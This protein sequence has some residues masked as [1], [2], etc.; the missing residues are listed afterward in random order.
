M[1]LSALAPNP[2]DTRRAVLHQLLDESLRLGP[3]YE[4]GMASH[5]PMALAALD[6]LGAHEAQMRSFHAHYARRLAPAPA[7]AVATAGATR[8]R[9]DG[10]ID[11]WRS[12]RGRI[13]AFAA[14]R[15]HF[16]AAL[17]R[18]GRDALLRD[19]LPALMGGCAGG[20][21]HG[22]IR[23]AHAVE[24]GHDGELAAAL[25]YCAARWMPL[26]QPARSNTVFTDPAAWLDAIDA[27]QRRSAPGWRSPAPLISERMQHAALTGAWIELADAVV[28]SDDQVPEALAALAKAAAARYAATGNFT[29]L[30]MATASRAAQ[31]LAKWLPTQAAAWRP[32]LHAMAAA[33]IASR[34]MPL[35]RDVSDS[36]TWTDV[37]RA[38][39]AS[40]DDH[41][42]KLVHAMAMQHARTPD[43]VWLDAARTAIRS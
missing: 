28:L 30:H 2:V 4:A 29:V 5:L 3:E 14:L 18:D 23:V 9:A 1:T 43:P 16:S 36:L 11:D 27:H 15:R 33:S 38:A 32:L 20:A 10:M 25:A 19:V 41:V 34:A 26:P 8:E 39:C 37:R 42:I 13:D 24:S 21:F 6:G 31:V 22:P 35:Q 12:L 40:D 7:P 17:A